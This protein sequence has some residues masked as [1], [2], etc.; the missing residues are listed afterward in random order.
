MFRDSERSASYNRHLRDQTPFCLPNKV[1]CRQFVNAIQDDLYSSSHAIEDLRRFLLDD[2]LL[3]FAALN[4][5]NTIVNAR[6]QHPVLRQLRRDAN[7]A[8]S[9]PDLL[10][11]HFE[12]ISRALEHGTYKWSN[13]TVIRAGKRPIWI[14]PFRDQIL[15]AAIVMLLGPIFEP[16][17]HEQNY[18]WRRGRSALLAKQQ[19]EDGLLYGEFDYV[20][21][22]DIKDCFQTLPHEGVI[23]SLHKRIS[24][25]SFTDLITDLITGNPAKES[26]GILQGT[27]SAPILANVFLTGL[28]RLVSPVTMGSATI[29]KRSVQ[30]HRRFTV[31][32]V[33]PLYTRYCDDIVVLQGGD[34]AQAQN[35]RNVMADW[36][37]GH[38]M[39]LNTKKE[40]IG[41]VEESFDFVSFSL[42]R[43]NDPEPGVRIDLTQGRRE[44][45]AGDLV[46][47]LSQS[48][49]R[50]Y[51]R[52]VKKQFRRQQG[53][54]FK[55]GGV[56][57]R[58]GFF[59]AVESAM[60]S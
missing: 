57:L 18:G 50:A 17:L 27:V 13:P 14:R 40:H 10:R 44:R 4:R 37:A 56:P 19:V 38:G 20:I 60:E 31:G 54:Y 16:H 29:R 43:V 1:E 41:R 11:T 28:D 45:L 3:R 2:R 32:P 21:R 22:A 51:R 24:D 12:T 58:N 59:S 6:S 55:A 23:T 47:M 49:D 30:T 42:C 8:R 35:T 25:E 48:S 5:I 15:E 9:N 34:R 39:S 26:R 7:R 33:V 36:L 53:A 46:A 52:R